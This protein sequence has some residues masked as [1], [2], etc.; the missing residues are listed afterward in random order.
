MAL[1][2]SSRLPY[3]EPTIRTIAGTFIT[4][5]GILLYTNPEQMLIWLGM[6]F[7]IQY[8]PVSIWLHSIL[9]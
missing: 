5:L 7:F 2:S 8:Q 4:V 6:L 3:I 9:S 1:K